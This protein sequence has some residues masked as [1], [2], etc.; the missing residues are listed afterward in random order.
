MLVIYWAF[1]EGDLS[2]PRTLARDVLRNYH[3]E[4]THPD[5]APRVPL[6]RVHFS[7]EIARSDYVFAGNRE[8]RNLLPVQEL[9]AQLASNFFGGMRGGRPV[10][11]DCAMG[12]GSICGSSYQQ[13]PER[14]RAK[15]PRP[16]VEEYSVWD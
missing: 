14:C 15:F 13:S 3:F 5:F 16:N 11:E 10:V 2:V 1:I 6:Q 4:P 8:A 9:V 7:S 12:R